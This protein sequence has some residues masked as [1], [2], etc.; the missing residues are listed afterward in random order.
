MSYKA[1]SQNP[2]EA[3]QE[4]IEKQSEPNDEKDK[5][6]RNIPYA[7]S[8]QKRTFVGDFNTLVDIHDK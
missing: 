7:K 6:S 8:L 2:K 4:F 3:L 5:I 1:G